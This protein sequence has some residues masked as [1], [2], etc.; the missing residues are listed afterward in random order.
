VPRYGTQQRY[1]LPTMA[2][3]AS[4]A[5][6]QLLGFTGEHSRGL[7]I[8]RVSTPLLLPVTPP[9][10]QRSCT[11]VRI[12]P[13]VLPQRLQLPSQRVSACHK[14]RERRSRRLVHAPGAPAGA[15]AEEGAGGAASWLNRNADSTACASPRA[16]RACTGSMANTSGW[17]GGGGEAQRTPCAPG[18]PWTRTGGARAARRVAGPSLRRQARRHALRSHRPRLAAPTAQPRPA[19]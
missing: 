14:G 12:H 17:R 3:T 16:A 4:P 2:S 5:L 19:T 7:S 10:P 11:A 18:L 6:Q 1:R 9:P 8:A 13:C 15:R